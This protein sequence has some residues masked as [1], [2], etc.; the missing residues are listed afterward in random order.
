[1]TLRGTCLPY[2]GKLGGRVLRLTSSIAR[3]DETGDS[4]HVLQIGFDERGYPPSLYQFCGD[5]T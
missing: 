4:S 2:E 5:V 1:M 3:R